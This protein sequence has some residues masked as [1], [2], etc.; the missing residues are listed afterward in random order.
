MHSLLSILRNRDYLAPALLF[1]TL[2]I[3]ISTWV[4]YVP[5]VKENLRLDDGQLG[6]ALFCFSTG[7]LASIPP[8][9][10][11]FRRFGL[12]KLTFLAAA[13]YPFL[14][15]LPI[16]A[17]T[18]TWLIVFLFLAG[19]SSSLIDI[20]MNAI[21]SELEERD[22][23]KI[24]SAAHGFFSIGGVIGAGFGTILL[25]FIT[26]PVVHFIIVATAL[27]LLNLQFSRQYTGLKTVEVDR[28]EG[29][30]KFSLIKPLLGFTIL[31][32]ICMGTE[33][34]V[35]H[36]S[37]LYLLDVVGASS[38]QVAG[39]GY[40]AFSITMTLGRFLADGI[41]ARI[42]PFN[43]IISGLLLSVVGFSLVLL[44]GF[45]V[46]VFGFALVG[47]GFSVIVPELFRL[48]GQA[49]GVSSAEG[50]SVVAGLGYVGF[51]ASPAVLGF[52]S[53]WSSLWMSFATLLCGVLVAAMVTY[54][55]KRKRGHSM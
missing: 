6:I 40:V 7:L 4:L 18:Y 50:I 32:V 43:I 15:C 53:N 42:G 41:S 13:I 10:F 5:T 29:G 3:V 37:K 49:E 20:G 48:A 21:I 36:W 19:M 33:G 9:S 26:T 51:L 27:L 23:V 25:G 8:S 24:M 14:M 55:L 46:S 52:I 31:A 47:L 30:F 11:L 44:A 12:G 35:E 39:L 2:N 45:W 54:V 22:G 28:E 34:A 17:P 16:V 1:T 38:D